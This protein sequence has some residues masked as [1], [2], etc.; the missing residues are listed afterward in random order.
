MEV[1][2]NKE[3]GVEVQTRATLKATWEEVVGVKILM[4]VNETLLMRR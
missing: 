1:H 4:S 2:E 3:A